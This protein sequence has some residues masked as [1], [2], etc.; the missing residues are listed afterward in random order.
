M[1]DEEALRLANAAFTTSDS[2]FNVSV[3]QRMENDIR[4]VQGQHPIGSKYYSDFYKTRSKLF[5]PKT[6]TSLRKAEAACASAFFSNEDIVHIEAVDPT[7]DMQHASAA[8][9]KQLIQYRLTETLPWFQLVVGAY[10][11]A[12]TVGVVASLQTW[13]YETSEGIDQPDIQLLPAENV[14]IDPAANWMDPSNT[15]PYLIVLLPM[16]ARDVRARIKSEKKTKWLP[17]EDKDLISAANKNNDSIRMQREQGQ[18]DSKEPN[19]TISDFT[20]V[21]VHLNFVKYE[22]V[23]YTYYTLGSEKLLSKPQPTHEKYP[24]LAK[25]VRPVVFGKAVLQAHRAYPDSHPTMTKDVQSEINTIA[26]Q[27]I[28][29]VRMAMD[30]R[31][32]V[33]RNKS[34]DV[35]AL[36]RGG[37][38][39]V[40]FMDDLDDAKVIE[41]NDVTGSSYQEQ[42]RLNLDYDDLAGAFSGSSVASNRRLNETVGG[43]QLLSGDANQMGEYDLRVFTETWVEPVLKQLLALEQYYE[44]DEV[45]LAIAG[46]KARLWQKYGIDAVTDQLLQMNL[47]LKVNVGTG[48]TN[49]FNQLEKLVYGLRSIR[50]LLGERAMARIKDNEILKEIFGKLGYKD[51]GR[52]YAEEGDNPEIDALIAQVQEL[53]GMIAQKHPPELIAAQIEEIKA[54]AAGH[55]AKKVATLVE[56]VFSAMQTGGQIAMNP[57]IAPVGDKVM[58]AAGYVRPQGGQD[59]DIPVPDTTQAIGVNLPEINKNTS[60]LLPPVPAS[61]MTG[62][63][64]QEIEPL[65]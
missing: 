40:T 29:N 14:R 56:A 24:H 16:Y 3:R 36:V 11:E 15:S 52:F 33:R 51:G 21:W 6:R 2:Y 18:T 12:R 62:I 17:V 57:T 54:R 5:R 25:G 20:I 32:F 50:E 34:V 23:D 43:M 53:Q 46:E 48:S 10:Q 7:D 65:V 60:P 55:E 26:N 22:G 13:K 44:T 64:T 28:D 30:K 41:T 35:R 61:P 49:T 27:R 19:T 42:D 9:N 59:P 39:S 38:N 31:W 8:I 45:V 4:Q 1:T 63:E 37:S 47:T 58:E